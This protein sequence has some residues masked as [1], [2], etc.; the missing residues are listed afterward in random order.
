MAKIY[1][2]K[3]FDVESTIETLPD[4][5]TLESSYVIVPDGAAIIAIDDHG[6]IL[7]TREWRPKTQSY[8]W[9]IPAGRAEKDEPLI[10]CARREMRE[11]AGYDARSLELLMEYQATSSWYKQTKAIYLAKDIFLSPLNT[12]DEVIKPEIHFLTKAEVLALLNDGQ[13]VADVA[14]ALY[15]FILTHTR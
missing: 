6:R 12:G 7:I 9:R 11:E 14:A 5:T 10:D 3:K 15:R 13:I 8:I 1:S 2:G 4:G